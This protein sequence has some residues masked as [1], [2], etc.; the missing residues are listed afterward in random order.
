MRSRRYDLILDIAG[1]SAISRLR[2]A[3]ALGG[4]IVMVGGE[5]GDR[6]TGGMGRQLRALILSPF[7]RHRLVLLTP[8]QRASDLGRLTELIE[9]GTVTPSI[10]RTYR[11]TRCPTLSST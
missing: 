2:R 8:E 9:A 11:W 7:L 6:W 5:G 3:L 10:D 4:T 1:D